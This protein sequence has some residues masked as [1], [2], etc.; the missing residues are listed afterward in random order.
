M[1]DNVDYKKMFEK[2]MAQWIHAE[3]SCWC[4]DKDRWNCKNDKV[5]LTDEEIE[6]WNETYERLEPISD[7]VFFEDNEL[8]V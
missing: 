5:A 3:G 8:G 6:I 4:P 2:C 7:V 1:E